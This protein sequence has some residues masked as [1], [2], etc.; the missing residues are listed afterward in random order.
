MAQ[1]LDEAWALALADGS[2]LLCAR[3]AHTASDL[4]NR[5]GQQKRALDAA[6]LALEHKRHEGTA[7]I[8]LAN[9]LCFLAKLLLDLGQHS[10]G[11][12]Y[13]EEGLVIFAEIY[14]EEH[15]ETCLVR[16]LLH[17]LQSE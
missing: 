17:R 16:T 14:G 1:S 4:F 7:D 10:E 11:L 13:A 15:R 12:V 3:T 8:M 9:Y 2:S 5:A 6:R